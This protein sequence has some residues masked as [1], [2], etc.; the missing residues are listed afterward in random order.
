VVGDD[1]GGVDVE[2]LVEFARKA[3]VEGISYDELVK[4][5]SAKF[6]K[7]GSGLLG[8]WTDDILELR[9]TNPRLGLLNARLSATWSG[10]LGWLNQVL[11]RVPLGSDGRPI[12]V[13]KA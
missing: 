7:V 11:L 4:R 1:E 5:V 10:L 2:A 6:G 3:C 13:G 12:R 8:G 9:R